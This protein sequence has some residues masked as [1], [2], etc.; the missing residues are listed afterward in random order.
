MCLTPEVAAQK[1]A[2]TVSAGYLQGIVSLR[3]SKEPIVG[4]ALYFEGTNRGVI[5]D[6]N[7]KYRIR[8]PDGG[9]TLIVSYVG[10][11]T[12]RFTVGNQ[13]VLDIALTEKAES[14]GD[15]V[16][17]GIANIDKQTFT[18]NTVRIEKKELL[19]ANPNNLVAA[20]QTFDP[21]FRIIE[22]NLAGSNPNSLPEF[23][24]RGQTGMGIT[25]LDRENTGMLSQS[26]L[27]NNPNLPIF[28]LDGFEVDVEKI[29]DLDITRV[30]SI[31]ILKD[32]AATAMYGSRAANGV[33][34]VET[35]A[36]EPGKVRVQYNAK[37]SVTA[38]DLSSYNLM[39]AA[40]KLEAERLAGFFDTE[41]SDGLSPD[42]YERYNNVVA[43]VDTYWLSQGLR[44]AVNHDHS[45]YVDGGTNDLRW[46][47][48]LRY[49]NENGV[50]KRSS[51]ERMSAAF[52]IDF[53]TDRL[54]IKNRVEY[55]VVNV[56]NLPYN[57]FS[58]YSHRLPYAR[59]YDDQGNLLKILE[60]FNE[61][62]LQMNPLYEMDHLNNRD[63]S[64]YHEIRDNLYVNWD[65][66]KGLKLKADFSASL[67]NTRGTYFLDPNSA[68]YIG[69]SVQGGS[70]QHLRG[71]LRDTRT[72]N[73]TLEGNIRLWYNISVRKHYI[74]ATLA[75]NARQTFYETETTSYRGF[76]GGNLTSPEYAREVYEKPSLSD[77]K[78]RLAGAV[79]MGNYSYDNIYLADLQARIDGSSEFGSQH[80]ASGFWAVG[81]GVNIHNYDFLKNHAV[82]SMLKVRLSYGLTGKADFPLYSALDLYELE[83]NNW[84][85][86]GYGLYLNQ[87]GNSSLK[88]ERKYT[89]DYGLEL[90]LWRDRLYL[91]ASLYKETTKDMISSMTIPSST[92][93]TSYSQN[94]GQVENKGFELDLRITP[95]YT[96]NWRLILFGNMAHNRNRIT[97]ISESMRS[98]N[99]RIDALYAQWGKYTDSDS[100]L[101]RT[102]TKYYEGASMTSIYGMRSLGISPT[103]GKEVYLLADG[104]ISTEWSSS[105]WCV[106]GDTEPDV[107]GSFGFNLTYRKFT[108]FTS[109]LYEIG[110]DLYNS[111]L[112]NYVEN[113]DIRNDNV[114]RRV[115]TARWQKPGDVTTLKDIADRDV[116]TRATSRFVQRNN[117]LSFSSLSLSYDFDNRLIRR[118]GMSMLRLTLGMNDV[119]YA[120]TVKRERGLEYP[121]ART[122]NFTANITF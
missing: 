22:N 31:N 53:R 35:R 48:E 85:A 93:F 82:I 100:R 88:W 66:A 110:G 92:G 117:M 102:Y 116:T 118:W 112:V 29:Y 101:A 41:G 108:L 12:R 105:D 60:S 113:A 42:Y 81:A 24:M 106:I 21:S 58:D 77:K 121:F 63:D 51:R 23:V 10:M 68:Y 59:L 95:L 114:D 94:I 96:K 25:E 109:F 56:S 13:T 103:N 83:D 8:K 73:N 19:Q 99:N 50:M 55:G 69:G 20:L 52:S 107:K 34:V 120:S 74:N 87:M 78:T 90:G 15:V 104:N 47:A 17:T 75:L 91:K 97:E 84:Y 4:A 80:R 44:T 57:S 72:E 14:I 9:G 2:D 43:G 18:G 6:K 86:T 54:Q 122:F 7:G 45:L 46:G 11:E 38:P 115:L 65:I 76:P 71:E 79:L 64:K 28:I 111:T 30:H 1:S 40:E 37:V 98:Y 89:L 49:G 27:Q 61:T 32:A 36:P 26:E 119:F 3:S 67:R 62:D 33:I 70:N 39:N 5:S 16:V